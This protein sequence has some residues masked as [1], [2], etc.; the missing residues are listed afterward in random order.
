MCM[1]ERVTDT[2]DKA[3]IVPDIQRFSCDVHELSF[4]EKPNARS[5]DR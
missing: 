5:D 3:P 1:C 2:V 4:R